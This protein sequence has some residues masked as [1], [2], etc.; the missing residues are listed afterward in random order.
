MPERRV[1]IVDDDEGIRE[2]LR[3]L[4]EDVGYQVED[5]ST[6]DAALHLIATDSQPRVMLLDRMMPRR[7]GPSVLATLAQD[8]SWHT[9]LAIIFIT[10][11]SDPPT[12]DLATLLAQT[13]VATIQ[14]PFDLDQ[15]VATVEHAWTTLDIF[16][17]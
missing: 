6:A 4:F 3:F 16:P 1:L 8:A 5:V 10:A 13:T 2:S 15:V 14:K 12:N 11:R 17:S 7:D 9:R